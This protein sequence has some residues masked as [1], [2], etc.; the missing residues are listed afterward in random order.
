M[1]SYQRRAMLQI[2]LVVLLLAA[3]TSLALWGPAEPSCMN[4]IDY[5]DRFPT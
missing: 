1:L 5:C 4:D 3:F 2:L